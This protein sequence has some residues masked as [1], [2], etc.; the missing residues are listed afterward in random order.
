MHKTDLI[1]KMLWQINQDN[2]ELINKAARS[3]LKS[4]IKRLHLISSVAIKLL[5]LTHDEDT[6]IG[7]LSLLIE[8][9]P[10]LAAKILKQVNSAAYAL[11]H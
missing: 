9:E 1:E 3:I 7:Q 10:V 4:E 2:T 5:Q 11:P 6:R 8:T